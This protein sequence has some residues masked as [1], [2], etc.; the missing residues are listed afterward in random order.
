[1]AYMYPSTYKANILFLYNAIWVYAEVRLLLRTLL[2]CLEV[3]QPMASESRRSRSL[4]RP[5]VGVAYM[6]T[7]FCVVLEHA[8]PLNSAPK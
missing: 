3:V 4:L 8:L 7:V 6:F 2:P 1:M 5:R